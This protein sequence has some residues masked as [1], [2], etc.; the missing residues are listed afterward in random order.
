MKNYFRALALSGLLALNAYA[1]H[2]EKPII[3]NTNGVRYLV[4]IE[5]NESKDESSIK[6]SEGKSAVTLTDDKN[7]GTVDYTN[8]TFVRNDVRFNINLNREN[9]NGLEKPLDKIYEQFKSGIKSNSQLIF[10]LDLIPNQIESEPD[11]E[12]K[13]FKL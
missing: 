9:M 13:T 5:Y 12:T 6:I 1:E 8:L 11:P 10:D 7:D 4:K 3:I 2:I